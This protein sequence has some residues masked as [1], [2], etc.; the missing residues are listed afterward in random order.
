VTFRLGI[1]DG[2]PAFVQSYA[3][4][5][6]SERRSGQP[7]RTGSEIVAEVN[8]APPEPS[9]ELRVRDYYD[10]AASD[11]DRWLRYYERLMRVA[12]RRRRLLSLAEG[13]TLEVGVGTGVNLPHYARDLRL[14]GVD[15][16]PG[17]LAVAA[18]RAS[19]LGRDVDLRVGDVQRLDFADASF[20]TVV[21]TL[22]L[23]AVPDARRAFA[24]IGRVLK[25]G[26]RLLVLDHVRSTIRPVRWLQRLVEPVFARYALWHF[27]RDPLH[28]LQVAGYA[29]EACHRSGLGMLMELVVRSPDG[30]VDASERE[31]DAR[32]SR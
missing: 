9:D 31:R 11:Y 27:A 10:R 19:G 28:D 30:P 1:E 15:L 6:P 20:D 14:T 7:T 32:A 13:R 24:E 29:V 17:M 25:P 8:P 26:G 5:L 12:I 23:S 18:R 22:V 21:A 4:M 3:A 16:S 2:L